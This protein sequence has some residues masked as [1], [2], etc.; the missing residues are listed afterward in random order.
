MKLF[1]SSAQLGISPINKSIDRKRLSR[2]PFF[3]FASVLNTKYLVYVQMKPI[4]I[5]LCNYGF[6]S[7]R[8]CSLLLQ[9]LLAVA[10][11][12]N[13][14]VY[15]YVRVWGHTKIRHPPYVHRPPDWGL[16]K[17]TNSDRWVMKKETR[18]NDRQLPRPL[19]KP[20][21]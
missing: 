1:R 7:T 12:S 17:T 4:L 19:I 21:E 5:T 14:Y 18:I 2:K 8:N 13:V 11:S 9:W 6:I 20:K 10:E 15:T 16:T 3:L